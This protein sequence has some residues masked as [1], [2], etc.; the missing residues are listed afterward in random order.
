M[1]GAPAEVNDL[2]ARLALSPPLGI[3]IGIISGLYAPLPAGTWLFWFGSFWFVLMPFAIWSGARAITVSNR[4]W[5]SRFGSPASR[6]A[7]AVA[8]NVAFSAPASLALLY[9]WYGLSGVG[10]DPAAVRTTTL[11]AMLAAMVITHAYETMFLIQERLTGVVDTER[12]EK[13]RAQAELA[14]LKA[15]LD[16]HFLFNSL[17]ALSE[18]IEADPARAAEFNE[19]LAEVYRYI[20]SSKSR[21]TVPLSDEIRFAARYFALLELRFEGAVH[22]ERP[23]LPEMAGWEIP[24]LSA[25]MLVENAA[26]RNSFDAAHPLSIRMR[27]SE[28]CLAVEQQ[29]GGSR[30]EVKIPLRRRA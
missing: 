16:P 27:V 2:G 6:V 30:H 4:G 7:A 12:R 24:P 21:E 14:A 10:P 29:A 5:L 25:Q 13:A 1:A 3:G 23:A 22:L 18:L 9:T 26:R 28:G 15:Q 11:L 17:N 20:L 8:V 19:H